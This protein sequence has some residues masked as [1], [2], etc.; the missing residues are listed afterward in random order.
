MKKRSLHRE[1]NT[2]FLISMGIPF[3]I[4]ILFAHPF[5]ERLIYDNNHTATELTLQSMANHIDSYI[6]NSEKYFSQGLFDDNLARFYSYINRNEVRTDDIDAYYKYYKIAKKYRNS[7]V[8]Y[9][10]SIDEEIKE[11]SVVPESSNQNK[12]FCF[13]KDRS[14]VEMYDLEETEYKLLYD[15]VKEKPSYHLVITANETYNSNSDTFVI[16]RQINNI[17]Q[18]KR[19]AVVFLKISRDIFSNIVNNFNP[20]EQN[21]VV[22]LYPDG[23]QAYSSSEKIGSI[24]QQMDVE[25]VQ[26]AESFTW[27]G[28]RY[29]L[30]SIPSENDFTIHY[31]VARTAILQEVRKIFLI[32]MSVW[33]LAVLIAIILYYG[34]SKKVKVATENIMQFIA[35]YW[36]NRQMPAPRT[37]GGSTIIEFENISTALTDMKDRV[38]TLVEKEYLMKLNQQAAEYKALQTEIHPHFLNNVLSSFLALNRTDDKKGLEKAILNLSKMFRYTAEHEYDTRLS[39]E[40]RFIESYLM[41]QKLR[42]E[43]RLEYKIELDEELEGLRIPKL[44]IQPIVENAMKHGFRE[45]RKMQILI[46]AVSFFERGRSCVW[47]M[48]ANNGVPIRLEELEQKTGVGVENVK[49]RLYSAFPESIMYYSATEQFPTICNILIFQGRT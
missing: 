2:I 11:I 32:F 27:D 6:D 1:I 40:C 14:T 5:F 41:L 34:F 47:I 8:R 26:D 31:I 29:Y 30:T 43:E 42:F 18:N 13:R 48:V 12:V 36:P 46:K 28:E 7:L 38:E 22:I 16:A 9:S 35:S 10:Y 49:A 20:G 37:E 15:V 19:Q 23:S 4:L 33:V 17:E 25:E 45:N 44:L 39:E 21:G 3:L 24:Y